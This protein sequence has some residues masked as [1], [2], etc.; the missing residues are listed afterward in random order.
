MEK[1]F[2]FK[3]GGHD[4]EVGLELYADLSRWVI[5]VDWLRVTTLRDNK[6][7]TISVH[8]LCFA[9]RIECWKWGKDG[10]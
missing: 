2:E 9:L 8:L 7:C 6:N 4:R 10:K 5:G 3:Y 1:T